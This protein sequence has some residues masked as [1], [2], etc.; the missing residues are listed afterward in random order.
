MLGNVRCKYMND[1]QER[2]GML[3]SF[4]RCKYMNV[5]KLLNLCMFVVE[6]LG[7]IEMLWSFDRCNL[8]LRMNI[9]MLMLGMLGSFDRCKYMNEC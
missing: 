7:V 1:C 6:K 9:E 2:L 4:D 8:M 5:C 3:W